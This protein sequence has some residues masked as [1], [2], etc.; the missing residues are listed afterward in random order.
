VESTSPAI[1]VVAARLVTTT[2]GKPLLLILV[3]LGSLSTAI[4]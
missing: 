3:M 1:D 2:L 4:L